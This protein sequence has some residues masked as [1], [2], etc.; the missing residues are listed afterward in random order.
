MVRHFGRR[1]GG[2][3]ARAIGHL[4]VL[5]AVV[6][7]AWG[8]GLLWFVS[9]IPP[10]GP[11]ASGTVELLEH[12]DAI[13]VL[14]GG[15]GRLSKG[16]DLLA[17]GVAEKLFVSGVYDG[18]DVQEL[19]RLSRQD[20]GELECCIVLG[21]A[22]DNTVG[23]AFETAD[24]ME[25]QGYR[26]LR[27]VTSN[28]HMQR[29]LLEFRMAMPALTIIPHPVAPEGLELERWWSR[30]GSANLLINEYN[31]YLVALLRFQIETLLEP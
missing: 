20:P 19:L 3:V 24:W 9:T 28:Y 4:L 6:L 17:E 11:R 29:S 25:E 30:R 21:Y 22:A 23:N 12:T 16:L 26:S 31:K 13:V 8:G 14:T 2:S 27:L 5:S 1:G 15:S 18:V 10:A 7:L